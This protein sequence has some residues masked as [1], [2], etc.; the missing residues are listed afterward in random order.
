MKRVCPHIKTLSSLLN[1][2]V[3]KSDKDYRKKLK[4]GLAW[5]KN[6]IN[7]ERVIGERNLSEVFTWIDAA[8]AVHGR[9]RSHT[10]GAM[11]MGYGIIQKNPSKHK[12]NVNNSIEEELLVFSDYIPYNLWLMMFL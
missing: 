8:Y 11:Q 7:Y 6:T 1:T 5:V 4:R 3:S 2:G 10:G 12:I 9:T